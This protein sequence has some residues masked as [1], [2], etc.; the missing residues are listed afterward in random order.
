M[1]TQRPSSKPS[2]RLSVIVSVSV[3]GRSRRVHRDRGLHITET[4]EHTHLSGCTYEKPIQSARSYDVECKGT[5]EVDVDVDVEVEVNVEVE[6]REVGLR[7]RWTHHQLRYTLG[8]WHTTSS[9]SSSSYICV[10]ARGA[11][12]RGV[13]SSSRGRIGVAI[14]ITLQC[15]RFRF[16][17]VDRWTMI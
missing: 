8:G 6:R 4:S 10:K 3:R 13:E 12:S 11:E 1:Y 14:L 7:W 16:R 17:A 5:V 9:P 15:L 2:S